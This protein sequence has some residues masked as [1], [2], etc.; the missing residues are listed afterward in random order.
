MMDERLSPNVKFDPADLDEAL[1]SMGAETTGQRRAK[2]ILPWVGSVSLHILLIFM[3]FFIPWTSRYFLQTA[4]E[5]VAI[6]ADFDNLQPGTLTAGDLGSVKSEMVSD[7]LALDT[8]VLDDSIVV[9]D[10][11][12]DLSRDV[13]LRGPALSGDS[14]KGFAPAGTG[15]TVSFGGLRGSNVR[16]IVYVV[17]ASGSMMPYLP[18]VINEL[19]R[20]IDRLSESQNFSVV[21]FQKNDAI[22]VPGPNE[23]VSGK[24]RRSKKHHQLLPATDDNKNFVFDWINLDHGHIRATGKSNPLEAIKTALDGLTPQADVIF[25]LST[26]ITGVGEFEIDQNNLLN[27]IGRLN[28]DRH[29]GLKAVI[30]TIQF[31]DQDPLETLKKIAEQNGGIDGYRFMSRQDLGLG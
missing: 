7:S 20:S 23:R 15:D 4:D 18:V 3:G 24:S 25:I 26:D 8:P 9:P 13:D 31:I 19:I 17:D 11:L 10:P 29:G 28:R 16:N 6:V 22:L 14:I 30:K 1:R 2:R 5:P 27:L 21:F 12:A